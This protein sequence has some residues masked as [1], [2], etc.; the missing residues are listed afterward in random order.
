RKR[1]TPQTCSFHGVSGAKSFSDFSWCFSLVHLADNVKFVKTAVAG[2][3]DGGDALIIQHT[4]LQIVDDA[5]AQLIFPAP[6]HVVDLVVILDG[7]VRVYTGL[8]PLLNH[9]NKMRCWAV[10]DRK[11]A[12][13]PA[14]A[15][16]AHA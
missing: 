16:L 9:F 3:S 5:T 1:R 10:G 15:M 12:L 2:M 4:H 8:D 6:M 13:Y 11:S 7:D 14:K